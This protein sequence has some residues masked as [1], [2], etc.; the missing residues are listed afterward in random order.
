MQC[1]AAVGFVQRTTETATDSVAQQQ[2]GGAEAERCAKAARRD[3]QR[4][5]AV[6]LHT[7]RTE[8]EQ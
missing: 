7:Q 1:A 2:R 3:E 6:E 5:D 4:A 8:A